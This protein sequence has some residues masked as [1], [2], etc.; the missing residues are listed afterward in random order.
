[1]TILW[2][3]FWGNQIRRQRK[4]QATS[5]LLFRPLTECVS[6]VEIKPISCKN[7]N[8]GRIK[9]P[10]YMLDD[11]RHI[12]KTFGDDFFASQNVCANVCVCV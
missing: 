2:V 1:M 4:Q 5:F 7:G 12:W 11:E 3:L 9:I 6:F 10:Q 8:N